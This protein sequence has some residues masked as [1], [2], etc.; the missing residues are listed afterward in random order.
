MPP[1]IGRLPVYEGELTGM[2]ASLIVSSGHS[3]CNSFNIKIK[4]N[5]DTYNNY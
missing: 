3:R 1:I 4:K 2:L 5:W